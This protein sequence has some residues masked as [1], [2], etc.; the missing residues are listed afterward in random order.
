MRN[1]F[2]KI[3]N[4]AD[5]LLRGDAEPDAFVRDR[6]PVSNMNKIHGFYR[7]VSPSGRFLEYRHHCP[8][9]GDGALASA[10]KGAVAVHCPDRK[11]DHFDP[12]APMPT[13]TKRPAQR[14][15]ELQLPDGSRLVLTDRGG[16]NGEFD[17]EP[18]DPGS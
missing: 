10:K 12:D 18:Y 17:Y 13:V 3:L 16:F 7:L 4:A 2:S 6:N 5:V 9:S 11:R 15:G 8:V 14:S 1:I